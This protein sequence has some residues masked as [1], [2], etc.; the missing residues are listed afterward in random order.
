MDDYELS[1][2][3]RYLDQLRKSGVTNMFGAGACL[4]EMFGMERREASKALTMWMNTF[5]DEPA[6]DRAELALKETPA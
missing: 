4:Q 6:E 2:I 1:E 3:F 5:S